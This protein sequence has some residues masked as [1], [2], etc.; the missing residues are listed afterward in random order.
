[1]KIFLRILYGLILFVLLFF[2][3]VEMFLR[4]IPNDYSY[5][6]KYLK[7]NGSQIETLILGISHTF[8]GLNPD[9]FSTKTFNAAH[10]S[11]SLDLDYLIFEKYQSNFKKLK[12]LII[13]ISYFSYPFTLNE[14]KSLDKITNYNI[15]YDIETSNEEMKYNFELFSK[16]I[17]KNRKIIE[18]YLNRKNLLTIYENGYIKVRGIENKA[19]ND[20]KA[21]VN[22]HTLDINDT[23]VKLKINNNLR[24]LNNI[25]K[26]CEANNVNVYLLSTP[27]SSAYYKAINRNQFNHWKKTT[28][29]LVRKYK[30]VKWINFLENPI[31]FKQ[32]DFRDSDHLSDKG[33][34]KLSIKVD[35]IIN[36]RHS[37][38]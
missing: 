14:G 22:R 18:D 37:Q 31:D 9:Y 13:P 32:E 19:I 6:A 11:Q 12:N 7:E 26:I 38:N 10:S 34:I 28:N 15:Y 35:S 24:S 2:L 5:K 36:K 29:E 1:M 27:T 25:I 30:N 16:P 21:A 33:A 3:G 8:Y 23:L 4:K 17:K 20:Y